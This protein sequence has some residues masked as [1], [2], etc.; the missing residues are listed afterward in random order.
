[1]QIKLSPILDNL[2]SYRLTRPSGNDFVFPRSDRGQLEEIECDI[3][4]KAED[5]RKQTQNL[6][7]S[8]CR[9]ALD[10]RVCSP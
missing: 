8:I 6:C 1:M 7:E 3:R 9:S 10:Q 2:D 5:K 4:G